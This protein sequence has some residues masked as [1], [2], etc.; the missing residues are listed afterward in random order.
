MNAALL[1]QLDLVCPVCRGR[2]TA[3][4]AP[5]RILLTEVYEQRGDFVIQGL[6]QCAGPDCAARFPIVDGVPI[7]LRDLLRWWVDQRP[8]V[9]V[10]PRLADGLVD[11]FSALD[12]R[13][14]THREDIQ[15]TRVYLDAHYGHPDPPASLPW[16]SGLQEDYWQSVTAMVAATD[17]PTGISLDLGCSVGR[18]TV[19]LGRVSHLAVGIDI[20]FAAVQRAAIMQRKGQGTFHRQIGGGRLEPV[21]I[22]VDSPDNLLFLVADALDPPF[23]AYFF[24]R[25][26]ALNQLDNVA[27]PTVLLGQMDALLKTG[28]EMLLASPYEWRRE[29]TDP[30][31]WLVDPT[32]TSAD[33]VRAI[34]ANQWRG[35]PGLGLNYTI[36]DEIDELPWV[37]RNH[38]R[39]WTVFLVHLLRSRKQALAGDDGR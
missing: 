11:L 25:V 19:E 17:S 12:R 35:G 22:A 39:H 34:L 27:Y 29:I 24:D 1:D 23:E 4:S 8:H 21:K 18:L 16:L 28:G 2:C 13:V 20:Q 3:A 33:V 10:Q 9:V 26:A 36:V 15:A 30:G 38:D 32:L 14:M 31:E 5:H 37:L 6:L 7:I